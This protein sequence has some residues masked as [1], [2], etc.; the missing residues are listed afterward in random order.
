MVEKYLLT[1]ETTISELDKKKWLKKIQSAKKVVK[2]F[3]LGIAQSA[4][5]KAKKEA[6]AIPDEL[7]RNFK[8][9]IIE[10]C[11]EQNHAIYQAAK[12]FL[13]NNCSQ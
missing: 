10:D 11:R 9:A 3:E 7:S 8:L 12:L 13:R 1:D 4:Y 2:Q 6:E 5:E